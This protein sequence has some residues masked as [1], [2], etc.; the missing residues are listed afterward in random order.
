MNR[1]L[2][3]SALS[4]FVTAGVASAQQEQLQEQPAAPPPASQA[5]AKPSAQPPRPFPEGARVGYIDLTVIAQQSAEG[6]T[7]TKQVQ[8]LQ[9][10][11]RGELE[12]KQKA[13]EEAQKK[14]QEGS[15]V[16][17][18]E[19]L[20][21][22]REDAEN[23]QLELQ[24]QTQMANNEVSRLQNRLQEQIGQKLM[25]IIEKVALA[26]GLHAVLNRDTLVWV[27]RGVDVTQ[28]VIKGLDAARA[29][30]K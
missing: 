20:A 27:D 18:A 8:S 21:K 15:S 10:K 26:K 30:S 7:M 23:L 5:P 16:M 24:Y 3:V 28:D 25:P 9:A 4:L 17:N 14:L 19:A 12:A 2:A 22:L 1:N 11:K 13:L 6:Q 29:T